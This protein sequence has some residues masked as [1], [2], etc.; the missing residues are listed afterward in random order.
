MASV[1]LP[2]SDGI[3][4]PGLC[5]GINLYLLLS[6]QRP[7]EKKPLVF[8]K[9]AKRL[10]FAADGL[11]ALAALVVM[12]T[13]SVWGLLVL[14]ILA[15]CSYLFMLLASIVMKPIEDKINRG[16]MEDAKS[17]I[18]EM[19]RLTVCAVTGSYGKTSTKVVLGQVLSEEHHTMIR[20][21]VT[22]PLWVDH[23]HPYHVKAYS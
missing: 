19:P 6:W 12:F 22:I 3:G 9:R 15:C 20:R 1:R 11:A 2:A 21:K 14:S 5:F 23:C 16:F 17:I 13:G 8:T 10:Y 4:G 18:Q 7:L